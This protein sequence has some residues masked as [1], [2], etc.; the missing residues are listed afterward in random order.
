MKVYT[1]TEAAKLMRLHP[2]TVR[3]MVREGKLKVPRTS[4]WGKIL[5]PHEVVEKFLAAS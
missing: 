1:V 5:I 3:R 2:E 4:T